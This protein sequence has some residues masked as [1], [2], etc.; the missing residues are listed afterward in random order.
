M[1]RVPSTPLVSSQVIEKLING[2]TDL[3]DRAI[4]LF[5]TDTGARV[6]EPVAMDRDMIAAG[7]GVLP[8]SQLKTAATGSLYKRQ[9]S[10][11]FWLKYSKNGKLYRESSQTTDRRKA[12]R[13]LN[14]R[15]PFAKSCGRRDFNLSVRALEALT[16]YL[17]SREDTNLALFATRGGERLRTIQVR[18]LV[19]KWCDRLGIKRFP[20]YDFRRRFAAN[21]NEG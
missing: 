2:V 7:A 12:E 3:R 20:I 9:Y 5:L 4:I 17:E 8:V 15:L 10:A 11:V 14:V 21:L 6:R 1:V 16:S 13:M 18:N 19:H